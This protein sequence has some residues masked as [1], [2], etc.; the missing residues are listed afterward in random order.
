MKCLN[1]GVE[2]AENVRVCVMCG[3][4]LKRVQETVMV[5]PEEAAYEASA[6]PDEAVPDEAVPD[7]AALSGAEETW[8]EEPDQPVPAK[9]QTLK[10]GICLLMALVM[11]VA[12]AAVVVTNVL[13]TK[14]TPEPM[15]L[16]QNPVEVPAQGVT[17][18]TAA[19]EIPEEVTPMYPVK[20]YS[21]PALVPEGSMDTVVGKFGQMELTNR[22]L[23]L[24][25]WGE[26]RYLL[27]TYGDYLTML[28]DVG[29]PMGEQAM[30]A[31]NPGYT[32]QD[33]LLESAERQLTETY[34]L[35]EMAH[36]E[37]YT[38]TGDDIEYISQTEQAMRDYAK[39]SGYPNFQ[40]Y[41]RTAYGSGATEEAFWTYLWDSVEASSYATKL[42]ESVNYTEDEIDAY[43][44]AHGYE[45]SGLEKDDVRS[46]D[47]RHILIL[48]DTDGTNG[49]D[50]EAARA[51]AERILELWQATPT[52]DNFAELAG[53][54]SEDPGS[55]NNGGLYTGVTPGEMVQT[56]NDWCFDESR[57]LGD[58]GIVETE[59]GYHIMYF[60]G[61]GERPLW[62]EQVLD[63]MR[64]EAY[65]NAVYAIID[66]SGYALDY[67][68]VVLAAPNG[69]YE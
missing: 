17:D 57:Q 37:G 66:E 2:N 45:H 13:P 11:V 58:T 31:N 30:Q 1:C 40:D 23:N 46:I 33:Y 20:A 9:K 6:V 12:I 53:V 7:E 24:Y 42:Y 56:F 55:Q 34:A 22:E 62:M 10:R 35:M 38:L 19:N 4:T 29:V 28:M 67:E 18:T 3:A 25:Y 32:W 51:E 60:S 59:Y 15:A 47:V 43:Y 63:D 44:D 5:L 14:R 49:E 16:A 64:V 8:Q 41:L 65:Q 39:S 54:Y 26:Y 68:A 48:P 52:E 50:W 69:M 21:S 61:R 27:N 36:A